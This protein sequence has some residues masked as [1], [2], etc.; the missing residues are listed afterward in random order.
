MKSPSLSAPSRRASSNYV[1]V[2]PSSVAVFYGR[3]HRIVDEQGHAS[4]VGFRVVRGGA[5]LRLP[6]LEKVAYLSLNVLSIPLEIERAYTREGVPV[7][8]EAVANVKI[9]SDD[10]SLRAA[11]ER[12]LGMDPKEIRGVIFQTLEG[13]LRAILG[14]LT[15]EEINTDRQA[16]AQKMAGEAAVDLKR[17]GV[18]IDILTIQQISDEQGYL[19][20]LG[21]KRTDLPIACPECL[22]TMQRA[23]IES[24]ACS[25][26]VRPTLGTWFD[27]AELQDVMRAYNRARER[28]TLPPGLPLQT[29]DDI[30][31]MQA[32]REL[33]RKS[34]PAT[35]S[36]DG[37]AMKQGIANIIQDL[38]NLAD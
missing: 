18:G 23:R 37:N 30:A 4:T 2:P 8:V 27:T 1:K 19:E 16:F 12:F 17:M 21:K 28:G 6:V 26:D 24:A 29:A 31:R 32:Q 11:A 38:K 34:G 36:V 7:T 10:V 20:A 14:N 15:V 25:I 33:E 35:V 13:H 9:A 22:T 3:K 5:A